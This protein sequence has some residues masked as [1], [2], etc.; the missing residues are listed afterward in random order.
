MAGNAPEVSSRHSGDELTRT[1][2]SASTLREPVEP[3]PLDLLVERVDRP[4]HSDSDED[5]AQDEIVLVELPSQSHDSAL[6]SQARRQLAK[7]GSSALEDRRSQMDNEAAYDSEDEHEDE[8]RDEAHE[9]EHDE[10]DDADIQMRDEQDELLDEEEESA[11]EEDSDVE[12]DSRSEGEIESIRYE[13]EG[14]EDAVPALTEKYQLI[15]R[16]GEGTFSS[17]YKAI[18][19]HHHV[20]DNSQWRPVSRKGKVYVAVKRIYVTSSPSRIQNELELLHDLRGSPNVAYL[21]DAIR[22]EDQVLAVMPFNRHQDFRTYYRTATLP[23]LRSYF[24][25]LFRALLSTHAL[26]IIHRDVK[27]A[28]FLYDVTTGEGILCDYGLAQKIGGDEWFEWKSDCLHSLPGPSWGGLDGRQR[29]MRKMEKD[30]GDAPGLHSG[31][32]GVRLREPL[33]LYVQAKAMETEWSTWCRQIEK[34]SAGGV[35]APEDRDILEQF[36]PW[37]MP[38]GWRPDIK[39]RITERQ[40]FYKSWR[41]ALQIAAQKSKQ[42]PGYL[43]EDRRPSV[44]A[45]RAG[46]RGFRAPEVLL[47]CPDQTVAVDIWSTGIILLC[48]LT[49]RFPFFNSNDDTEALAE[50][51]AIFGRRKMERCA[52]LHNRTL[53]TNI[54]DYDE[55]AHPDLH[56]LVRALNPPIVVENSPDPYGPVPAPPEEIADWYPDSELAQCVDLLKRCLELDCTKR[57]TAHE[58]LEHP[59]FR[60]AYDI[61]LGRTVF[62]ENAW[63]DETA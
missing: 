40:E 58:C 62:R 27:P 24:S 57:W 32:H 35:V 36:K 53:Q 39:K 21:I 13:M 20:F 2:R 63:L 9:G 47:K 15:D 12:H 61:G 23:F 41:P 14:V 3:D 59:F 33:S 55:P 4:H 49:R 10:G 19:L 43:K 56:A 11:E 38:P 34:A 44:R 7:H 30:T 52:A 18:D 25:C 6:S 48:F 37:I 28:N 26:Q 31:L 1:T 8:Y 60:G 22:H 17:V 5:A 45:N 54:R 16:L 51:M 42:R 46:T 29:A 50:I